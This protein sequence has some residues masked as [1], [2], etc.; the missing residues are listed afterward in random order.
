MSL[1]EKAAHG[2]MGARN[3]NDISVRV[4]TEGMVGGSQEGGVLEISGQ[5]RCVSQS[6]QLQKTKTNP[7]YFNTKEI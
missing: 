1:G 5:G 3:G 7:G 2:V 4:C 6:S